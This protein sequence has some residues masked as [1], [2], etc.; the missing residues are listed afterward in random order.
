LM[1][2]VHSYAPFRRNTA[3]TIYETIGPSKGP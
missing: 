3:A 1:R 2:G